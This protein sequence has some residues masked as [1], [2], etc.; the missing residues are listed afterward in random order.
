MKIF[1]LMGQNQTYLMSKVN[2]KKIPYT[3]EKRLIV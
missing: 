3:E 2:D 1:I